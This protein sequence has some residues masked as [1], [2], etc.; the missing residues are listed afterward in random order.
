MLHISI[1]LQLSEEL[2]PAA[3]SRSEEHSPEAT[4]APGAAPHFPAGYAGRRRGGA[5]RDGGEKF[6][7]DLGSSDCTCRTQ[8]EGDVGGGVPRLC[9]P[10]AWAEGEGHLP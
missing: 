5:G 3:G 7:P 8:G 1:P 6:F 2:V 10:R 4:L 9:A